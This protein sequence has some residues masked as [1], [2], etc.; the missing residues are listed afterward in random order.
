MRKQMLAL[1]ALGCLLSF[2]ASAPLSDYV[3]TYAYGAGQTIEI[4]AGDELFSVLDGA[5]Y[6][7]GPAGADIFTNPG[8]NKVP[9]RR[10]LNGTV[11]GLEDSGVFHARISPTITKES[12]A[13]AR[14]RPSGQ[15]SP[16]SYRYQPPADAHDGIPVGDIAKTVLGVDTAN[17]IVRGILEAPIRT[18][19]ASCCSSTGDS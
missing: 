18:C 17:A 3:G 19:T 9:F 11:T 14:P 16:E 1:A 10:D 8:G 6:R 13:L 2:G 4:V 7:L 5:K 15:D 12:G